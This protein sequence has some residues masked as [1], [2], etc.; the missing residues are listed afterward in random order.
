MPAK[1]VRRYYLPLLDGKPARWQDGQFCF[2]TDSTW[3]DKPFNPRLYTSLATVK[4]RQAAHVA[5]RVAMCREHVASVR[6]EL[7]YTIIELPSTA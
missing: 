6:C 4:R 2:T 5:Y 7:S 3:R 1:T